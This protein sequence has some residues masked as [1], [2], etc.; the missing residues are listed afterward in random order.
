MD[1]HMYKYTDKEAEG[2]EEQKIAQMVQQGTRPRIN[3]LKSAAD[4]ELSLAGCSTAPTR[5]RNKMKPSGPGKRK[6]DA[7]LAQIIPNSYKSQ[8]VRIM[9]AEHD[10]GL[11]EQ[12]TVTPPS[13]D[14][15]QQVVMVVCFVAG[16]Y[17]VYKGMSMLF[18]PRPL[19]PLAE[20]A[21]DL[22]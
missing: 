8:R 5:K 2:E 22:S 6:R 13:D 4:M 1:A 17:L 20:A 12:V 7:D 21:S 16:M 19:A 14:G 11:Q 9:D 18:G 3:I 10:L 15:T